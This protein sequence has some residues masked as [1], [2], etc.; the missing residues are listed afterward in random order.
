MVGG[1]QPLLPEIFGST[2]PRWSEIADF[3]PTFARSA[4]AVTPSKKSLINTNRMFTTRFPMSLRWSSYVAPK[5][6]RGLKN[7]KWPFS[8]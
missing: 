2:G 3:E 6:Q 4:S 5:P 7:A 8:V 1:G